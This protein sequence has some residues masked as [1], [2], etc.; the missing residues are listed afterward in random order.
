MIG[1]A[2]RQTFRNEGEL[3]NKIAGFEGELAIASN[4]YAPPE[5]NKKIKKEIIIHDHI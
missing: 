1:N 5:N 3:W 2:E 4:S